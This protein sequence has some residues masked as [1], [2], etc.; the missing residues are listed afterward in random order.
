MQLIQEAG[1]TGVAIV[2]LFVIALGLR[3]TGRSSSSTPWAL[4]LLAAGQ[5]GQGVAQRVVA[6]AVSLT[7]D[8]VLV[9][10]QGSAEASANLLL[11]GACV[12]VLLAVGATRDR[13]SGP[14]I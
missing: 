4:A 6:G 1:V 8:P 13:L 11:A 12:L 7:K 9:L 5:L 3:A 2:G 10:A 14:S